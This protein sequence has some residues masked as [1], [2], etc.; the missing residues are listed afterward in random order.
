MAEHPQFRFYSPAADSLL[1]ILHFAL[2][3]LHF[4]PTRQI[5]HFKYSPSKHVALTG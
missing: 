4:Q 1:S 2:C 5:K 3:I